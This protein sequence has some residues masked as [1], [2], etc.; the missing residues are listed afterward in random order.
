MRSKELICLT[1]DPFI[2]GDEVTILPESLAFAEDDISNIYVDD[3]WWGVI[4]LTLEDYVEAT[5][6]AYI[7]AAPP[8]WG[9]I[10][11]NADRTA[12]KCGSAPWWG[13]KVMALVAAKGSKVLVS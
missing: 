5:Y 3:P 4:D 7:A 10:M 13:G 2:P 11:F 6:A 8:A 9:V 1:K 12:F